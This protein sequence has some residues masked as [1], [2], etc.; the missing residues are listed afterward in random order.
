MA[1]TEEKLQIKQRDTTGKNAKSGGELAEKRVS[2]AFS[3]F[4]PT[5]WAKRI[6]RDAY[7]YQGQRQEVLEFSARMSHASRRVQVKL[8]TNVA[9][10]AAVKA[11]RLYE[12]I[13][14]VGVEA[15]L[16][17][18]APDKSA[19]LS[20]VPTI[21]QFLEAAQQ[22][23]D[24]S[25]RTF[26]GYAVCFRRI[27]SLALGIRSDESKYDAQGEG[28]KKWLARI[29]RVRLDKL[30]PVRVQAA[31]NAQVAAAKGNPQA[32][33]RARTTAA[34][35]L[36]QAKGLFAKDLKLPFDNLP[37]PFDGVRVKVGTP[38]KYVSTVDAGQLLRAAK[39]ELAD[40]D[41]E[42]YKALLLGLGAG[43][44]RAEA[45]NLQW[46]QIDVSKGVIRI[47]QSSTFHTKTVG[48]EGE[49]FVDPGLIAELEAFREKAT[50]L[51]VLE[52]EL[53]PRPDSPVAFYRANC[54]FNRLT[55]WL[56]GQG[57]L[58]HKPLHLLR[59]EFGSLIA[60]SSDIFTASRQLRHASISTTA[61][62]YLDH[63]RKVA[64][65][66]GAML[67]EPKPEAQPKAENA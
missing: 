10:D 31:L 15:A 16:A 46:Q 57:I 66:I 58:S 48:S 49:I 37:N 38:R 1:N 36:R 20:A 29:E 6:F 51:Y 61:A 28:H 41:P 22:A 24:V 65:P 43:L 3:K 59:R 40:A 27:T 44:R 62:Y 4:T 14:A 23:A 47:M 12:R 64:P 54:T 9:K 39:S 8:G 13:K 50:G 63:R 42:A 32:E 60:A 26:R 25:P 5:Y 55:T 67:I 7:T 11:A 18:F 52:S 17:E 19:K 56:R 33:Q 53:T 35:I 21:G 45:D 30:T 34:S 2:P